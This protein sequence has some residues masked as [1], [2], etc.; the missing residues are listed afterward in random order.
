[1]GFITNIY[2]IDKFLNE[3]NYP[4]ISCISKETISCKFL[5]HKELSIGEKLS[6]ELRKYNKDERNSLVYQKVEEIVKE[7]TEKLILTNL[8]ILFNPDYK[9][10][11]LRLVVQLSKNKNLIIEWPG[12]YDNESLIYSKP[13]YLDYR[14]YLIKDYDI[15][16]LK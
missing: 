14:R 12:I 10:D 4:I 5:E 11:I 8:D 13:E 7:S 1:M 16:C 2:E 3:Y 9:L 6:S 15:L